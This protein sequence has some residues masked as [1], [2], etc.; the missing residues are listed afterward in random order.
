[1]LGAQLEAFR[2]RTLDAVAQKVREGGRIINVY[3]LVANAVNAGGRREI[4]GLE[5]T[6]ADGAGWLAFLSHWVSPR[7]PF[8]RN[9]P[10]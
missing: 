6:S 1:M 4:L 5:V 2:T 7:R 10:G 3:V 9:T 8:I